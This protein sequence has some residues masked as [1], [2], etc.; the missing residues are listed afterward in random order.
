MSDADAIPASATK[1]TYIDGRPATIT[2]RRFKLVVAREG[3]V[4]ERL[5]DKDVINIGAMEDNDLVLEDET[6]SR[7]HCRIFVEGDQYLIQDLDSTNG[8]FVNRVRIREAWL[9]PDV[10]VT[11]GKTEIRFQP[12]D[13]RVRIV[14]AETDRYGEIIG[15][16]RKMREI[17]AILEKIAPTDATVVIEGETGTGKDVVAR[18]IHGASKREGGPFM[19]FDC[20]A[21]P[22]NLIESELFGHEKG[23]FTG[24]HQTR[25]GVF[26]MA[27]GGTVFLDELGELQLDLQPKLLRVLE[28]REVK[29]IGGTKPIKVDVRIVAATNRN[30]EEEVRAGRFRED[31]FYRLTVVRLVL[32]PLR[33]RRDDVK[34]LA[35]H[36][37]DHGHFNKD[38]EGH[39]RVTQFAPGV[40]DRL[41]QY[42]WPGNVREL[43]NVIERAVSFSESDTVELADVPEHIAWPRGVPRDNDSETDVSIPLPDFRASELEGTFKDA[44]ERWVASFERDYIAGLLKK[45]NGNISHAAR[46]AEIDRKYFRKLMKKYGITAQDDELDVDE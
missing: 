17:Y 13:E 43:H 21:V 28:Q 5:F 12:F 24:A 38:R 7:N 23:S 45:N 34:L 9:R 4:E 15:R 32:P 44:K 30:L 27:N 22:E 25:Q 31:L 1:I 2:L 18:T 20:G 29:R 41:S 6:V 46:E 36:F 33:E 3:Q 35:R 8:T 10:V 14:P 37:L 16:D 26:E 11:L 40:L 39:R 19:V 42:D